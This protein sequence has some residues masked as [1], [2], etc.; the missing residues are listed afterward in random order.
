MKF[1][2][3]CK[4]TLVLVTISDI[5]NTTIEIIFVFFINCFIF[6]KEKKNYKT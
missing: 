1:I 2:L 6:L 3:F 5:V 4:L